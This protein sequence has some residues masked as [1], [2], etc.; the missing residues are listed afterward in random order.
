[1]LTVH[2]FRAGEQLARQQPEYAA[3]VER[4]RRAVSPGNLLTFVVEHG[5][6]LA[7]Q[8]KQNAACQQVVALQKEIMASTPTRVDVADWALMC[9]VDAAAAAEANRLIQTNAATDLSREL[10]FQLL[11]A[12]GNA[13]LEEY[14]ARKLAGEEAEASRLYREALAAGVPLPTM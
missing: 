8:V 7:D 14:W 11:P 10:Q 13:V 12:N 2:Q 4:T 3:L 1:M 6:P 9:R 5:G